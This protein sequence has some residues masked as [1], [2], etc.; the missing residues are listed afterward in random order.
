MHDSSRFSARHEAPI[1]SSAPIFPRRALQPSELGSALVGNFHPLPSSHPRA[2]LARARPR[3]ASRRLRLCACA[4][5]VPR[6]D[7]QGD[8]HGPAASAPRSRRPPVAPTARRALLRE[9]PPCRSSE[10]GREHLLRALRRTR[11]RARRGRGAQALRDDATDEAAHRRLR[12]RSGPDRGARRDLRGWIGAWWHAANRPVSPRGRSHVGARDRLVA[13]PC[14]ERHGARRRDERRGRRRADPSCAG[15]AAGEA[16]RDHGDRRGALRRRVVRV[17]VERLPPAVDDRR[18]R[19][20]LHRSRVH[21]LPIDVRGRAH[22]SD[23]DG[24]RAALEVGRDAR[25]HRRGDHRRRSPLLHPAP[26]R[27]PARSPLLVGRG[28][29]RLGGALARHD[30]CRPR[31]RSSSTAR[32]MPRRRERATRRSMPSRRSPAGTRSSTA[33]ARPCPFPRQRGRSCAIARSM[34]PP[35]EHGILRSFS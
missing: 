33:A 31:S 17:L 27:H 28:A 10:E 18:R 12:V 4:R 9:G 24:D 15:G 19:R 25:V 13:L 21:G 1:T 26:D 8:D 22:S 3:L 6:D 30:R 14:S 32:A 11:S 34:R 20:T 2:E 29:I 35:R 23:D 5:A 16:A 7:S